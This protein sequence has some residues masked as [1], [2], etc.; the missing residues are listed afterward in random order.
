MSIELRPY[1]REALDAIAAASERG[2][3]RPLI[4]LPTGCG[5][6][7]VFGHLVAD[8]VRE[9][10]AALI[11]AHRDELLQQAEEKLVMLAP[12]LALSVGRV[13]AGR[14]DVAAQCVVASVQTLANEKRLTQL[15]SYFDVVVVDE[16]HHATAD[17]YRR[18]LDAIDAPLKLGVTATPERHD[19]SRL[20]DVFE[21]IVFARSLLQM[22]EEGYLSNLRGVRVELQELDLSQVKVSRGDY[23]TDDLARALTEA[24]APAHTAAAL[25]EYAADRKS[26]VFVPTVELAQATADAISAAGLPA[27]AV[28][29]DMEPDARKDVLRRLA[30]GELRAVTNVDVLSEG[31]D[32]PSVDCIAI[33][34]PTRS[35]IAYVQRVGRGTRLY[36]GKRDCLVLDMVGITDNLKLQSLPA[37]FDLEEPP[38]QGESVTD[39]IERERIAKAKTE[40]EREAAEADA[41]RRT[42][43]GADLFSRDRLH[44]VHIGERWVLSMAGEEALVLDPSESGWQ[45]VWL[46]RHE[47]QD[48]A[49]ILMR[50]LD[51]GYAQGA[52]EEAVRRRKS[53]SIADTKAPWRR[54][55]ATR[56]QIA[57]LRRLGVTEIPTTAGDASDLI[58]AADVGERIDRFE[59]ALREREAVA[60]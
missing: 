25:A 32:E 38:K 7:L 29:G 23:Q 20:A 3:T 11:L 36:P 41:R 6:T 30:A 34:A 12:E 26:I 43:R 16:A 55:P 21:E 8:I 54:R 33:A 19:K 46:H 27:A 53:I 58:T 15:P 52:A 14:N 13:Q 2:V 18:I 37:L 35:R 17:S 24:H 49:R 42:A 50:N 44:W 48:L 51:L 60:A 57:K 40:A 4:A 47:R 9:G 1:Q 28:W 45:V 5:K 59:A 56:G 31:F 10:G 39:A 22:I